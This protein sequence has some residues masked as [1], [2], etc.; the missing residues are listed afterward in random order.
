MKKEN[1][2]VILIDIDPE[3]E[4]VVVCDCVGIL[5]ERHSDIEGKVPPNKRVNWKKKTTKCVTKDQLLFLAQFAAALNKVWDDE[6]AE[7]PMHQR[8]RFSF[9]LMGQGGSGKTAI[10]QEVVLPTMDFV[11]PL[12][13]N[14]QKSSL[15]VCS[16]WAQAENISNTEHRAMSCHKAAGMRVQKL[17]NKDMLPGERKPFLDRCGCRDGFWFWR[18]LA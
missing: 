1:T 14:G 15:I 8:E 3:K 11:F 10:V 7:V 18:R 16:S 9:L 12:D 6:Q 17:R 5:K 2:D 13:D 4:G